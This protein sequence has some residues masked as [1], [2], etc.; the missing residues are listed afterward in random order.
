MSVEGA[1]LDASDALD[2]TTSPNRIAF[3]FATT[4]NGTD[5]VNFTPQESVSACLAVG[6]PAGIPVYYGPLRIPLTPP[7][8][9][10]TQTACSL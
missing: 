1:G 9:L 5:G 6:V 8:D 4:G 10:E 3:T 7:F 2:F